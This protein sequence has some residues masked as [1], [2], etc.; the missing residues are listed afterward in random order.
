MAPGCAE[1]VEVTVAM[2]ATVAEVKTRVLG[3]AVERKLVHASVAQG[4]G[5]AGE[6]ALVAPTTR[7]FPGGAMA[8]TLEVAQMDLFT[9]RGA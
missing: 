2:T 5:A 8:D 9:E 1:E 7:T 3:A 4:A 6:F